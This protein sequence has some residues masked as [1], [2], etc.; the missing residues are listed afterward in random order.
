MTGQRWAPTTTIRLPVRDRR[1]LDALAAARGCSR[2][3]LV[4]EIVAAWLEAE[5]DADLEGQPVQKVLF[6][7]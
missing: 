5:K 7:G 3:E 2:S 1:R 6:D 4:R